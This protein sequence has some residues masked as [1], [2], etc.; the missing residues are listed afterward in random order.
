MP[1]VTCDLEEWNS[2]KQEL[3]E[4]R[5]NQVT[6][7]QGLKEC[8]QVLSRILRSTIGCYSPI[9]RELQDLITRT[10]AKIK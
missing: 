3:N 2:L 1:T 5:G 6:N 8:K 7:E 10:V 4:L 9:G